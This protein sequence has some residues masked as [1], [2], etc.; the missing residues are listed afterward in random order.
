MIIDEHS[1]IEKFEYLL[2]KSIK[3]QMVADV[4]VGAFLSGGL[5]S[6]T[7]VAIASRY[8]NKLKTSIY[9]C[10]IML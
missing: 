6:S 3:K 4:P 1:A 8:K 2:N 10:L 5:D 7:I 9:I